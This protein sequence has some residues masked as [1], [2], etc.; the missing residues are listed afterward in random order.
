MNGAGVGPASPGVRGNDNAAS[1]PE[2]VADVAVALRS[3][4][5]GLGARGSGSSQCTDDRNLQ[6]QGAREGFGLVEAAH[7][8]A[9]AVQ[10]HGHDGVDADEE[11]GQI[12]LGL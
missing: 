7:S 2:R 11:S 6:L 10:G 4:E 9:A 3:R 12:E 8:L 5:P 1:Q